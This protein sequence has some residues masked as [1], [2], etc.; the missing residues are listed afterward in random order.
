[1]LLLSFTVQEVRQRD[2]STWIRQRNSERFF[3]LF[4]LYDG[5][6]RLGIYAVAERSGSDAGQEI[7]ASPKVSWQVAC[8]T[9][10]KLTVTRERLGVSDKSLRS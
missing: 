8:C 10:L 9:S 3:V 1:M 2:G 7:F 4:V 6:V 5:L